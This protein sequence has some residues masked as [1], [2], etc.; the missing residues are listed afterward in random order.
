MRPTFA[1]TREDPEIEKYIVDRSHAKTALLICS[2]GCTPL[3]LFIDRPELRITV[4]DLNPHQIEHF[5][6][7]LAH[8][9]QAEFLRS[10]NTTG[11]FEGLFRVLRQT[12]MEFVAGETEIDDFFRE[13]NHQRRI[14]TVQ[15]WFAHPYGMAPY[16][17][18][19]NDGFL[20]IMFGK[21]ATQHA[22][23]NS[24]VPYFADRIQEALMQPK[25]HRNPYLQHIF[26]GQFLLRD[27]PSYYRGSTSPE[28]TIHQGALET[29]ER[30][31]EMEFVSLSNILDWS[32]RAY[33]KSVSERLK[34]L[35]SGAHILIRQLN[36]TQDWTAIF[37]PE[38]IEDRVLGEQCKAMQRGVF[39]SRY[40]ILI[41]R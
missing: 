41:R 5:Q 38:F 21:E 11:Y 32:T 20:H 35:P 2:G 27:A 18:S 29:V 34:Q 40:R 19:L 1:I 31:E 25:G 4:F 37:G 16:E 24:Y 14:A 22:F 17:V 15:R 6:Q 39:Y 13:E 10:I 33:G 3:S 30:L 26:L 8:I 9:G 7:K 23:A 28:Y 36:N 12:M